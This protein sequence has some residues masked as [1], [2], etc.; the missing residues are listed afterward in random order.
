MPPAP[1]G[2]ATHMPHRHLHSSRCFPPSKTSYSCKGNISHILPHSDQKTPPVPMPAPRGAGAWPGTL[3]HPGSQP[4]WLAPTMPWGGESRGPVS[5]PAG[6]SAT[7]DLSQQ[8]DQNLSGKYPGPT[9]QEPLTPNPLRPEPAHGAHCHHLFP[10]GIS[11]SWRWCPDSS[12]RSLKKLP[13]TQRDSTAVWGNSPPPTNSPH[14]HIPQPSLGVGRKQQPQQQRK[15]KRGPIFLS[16]KLTSL[17]P[18]PT[19]CH[20]SISPHKHPPIHCHPPSVPTHTGLPPVT[21]FPP[22]ITDHPPHVHLAIYQQSLK[23]PFLSSSPTHS[24]AYPTPHP[25]HAQPHPSPH[26]PAHQLSLPT[27]LPSHPPVHASVHPHTR[28]SLHC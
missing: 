6:G 20:P 28:P 10:W 24:P 19:Y 2:R 14:M 13:S 17:Y 26:V 22:P 4:T 3:T 27:D 16:G 18:P 7:S 1:S 8:H 12:V 11:L 23:T 21:P 15:G 9:P 5:M 25:S